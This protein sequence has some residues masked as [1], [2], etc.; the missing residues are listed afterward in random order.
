MRLSRDRRAPRRVASIGALAITVAVVGS[1]CLAPALSGRAPSARR[2]VIGLGESRTLA[3]GASVSDYTCSDSSPVR[4]SFASS[5]MTLSCGKPGHTRGPKKQAK[6]R[7]RH[8]RRHNA[9]S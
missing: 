3:A 8:H 9:K 2:I 7:R 6:H 4:S 1:V 5:Q